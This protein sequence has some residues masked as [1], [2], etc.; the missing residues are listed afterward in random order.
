M[1]GWIILGLILAGLLLL[2]LAWRAGTAEGQSA[3]VRMGA[4]IPAVA[5]AVLIGVGLLVLVGAGIWS[6]L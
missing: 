2:L 3:D 6:L 4:G 1:I 5:G